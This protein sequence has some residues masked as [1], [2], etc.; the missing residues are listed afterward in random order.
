MWRKHL[1]VQ[2]VAL[3]GGWKDLKSLQESYQQ[4]DPET[5]ESVVLDPMAQLGEEGDSGGSNI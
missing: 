4:A 1:P 5:V 2:D 3:A